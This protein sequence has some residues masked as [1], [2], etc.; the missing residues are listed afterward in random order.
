MQIVRVGIYVE[1]T[2]SQ[3]L[4]SIF[5]REIPHLWGLPMITVGKISQ[6]TKLM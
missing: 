5:L 2:R 4:I 3:A 1:G 6:E